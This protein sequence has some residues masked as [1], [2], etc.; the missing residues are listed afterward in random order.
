[1]VTEVIGVSRRHIRTRG[2][3]LPTFTTTPLACVLSNQ[4][5]GY[6]QLYLSSRFQYDFPGI[7]QSP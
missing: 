3:L 4:V 7:G 5:V 6:S 2:Y 1:M